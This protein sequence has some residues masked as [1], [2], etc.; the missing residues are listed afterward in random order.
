[1]NKPKTVAQQVKEFGAKVKRT[2]PGWY[3]YH[4]VNFTID[5]MD[6]EYGWRADVLADG[7]DPR[8]ENSWRLDTNFDTKKE[9]VATLFQMDQHWNEEWIHAE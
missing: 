6:D 7:V 9:L 2:M 8:L 1:M 4:G 3:T 5:I